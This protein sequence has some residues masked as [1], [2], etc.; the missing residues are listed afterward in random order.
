[1]NIR[2]PSA[3]CEK[4]VLN[5]K[6]VIFHS[7]N[8]YRIHLPYTGPVPGEKYASSNM[9]IEIELPALP[10][11]KVSLIMVQDNGIRYIRVLDYSEDE[12]EMLLQELLKQDDC[13]LSEFAKGQAASS[14]AVFK[15]MIHKGQKNSLPEQNF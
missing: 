7:L 13:G 12:I 15:Q 14:L 10:E 9:Y 3:G 6:H 4:N 1:M 5:L 11:M 2:N 8:P